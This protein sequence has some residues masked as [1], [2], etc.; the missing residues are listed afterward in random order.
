MQNELPRHEGRRRLS[1]ARLLGAIVGLFI[2]MPLVDRWRFGRFVESAAFTVVL[3]AAVAAV[4]SQRKTLLLAATMAIPALVGRWLSHVWSDPLVL[5]LGLAAAIVFVAF[6]IWNLLRFVMSSPVVDSEVL[7]TAIS[8]Y[9]LLAVAWGFSYELVS[10]WD[11]SEFAIT[12]PTHGNVKLTSFTSLY[13]SVQVLTTITF[14]DI[15]P[16]SNIARM[17]A[18]VEAAAGV[19]YMAILIARLVGLYMGQSQS[20]AGRQ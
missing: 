11:P 10:S 20:G 18:I 15:L 7:C 9:L 17:M 13:F 14:G 1:A 5:Q 16:V 19:F 2:V 4:G 8:S 3:L 6:I 12:E